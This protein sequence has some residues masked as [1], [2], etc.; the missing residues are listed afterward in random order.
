MRRQID[1]AE[2]GGPPVAAA[3]GHKRPRRAKPAVDPPAAFAAGRSGEMLPDARRGPAARAPSKHRDLRRS[4][5]DSNLSIETAGLGQTRWTSWLGTSARR[6]APPVQSRRS[7]S[8]ACTANRC[9]QSCL[10]GRDLRGFESGSRRRS[11]FITRYNR[12]D[13]QIQ[14]L[15][16]RNYRPASP[17]DATKS[18]A[19]RLKSAKLESRKL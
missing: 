15:L 5:R 8:I 17:A 1:A 18:R 11:S 2:P 6:L 9:S 13:R 16:R 19:R 3:A 10:A 7:K 4:G 12:Y 14:K